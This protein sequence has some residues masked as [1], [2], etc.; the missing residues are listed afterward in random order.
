M[1]KKRPPTAVEREQLIKAV[2]PGETRHYPQFDLMIRKPKVKTGLD[3]KGDK[4]KSKSILH[5]S[6]KRKKKR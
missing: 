2:K 1:P 4:P 6:L 5:P 3:K